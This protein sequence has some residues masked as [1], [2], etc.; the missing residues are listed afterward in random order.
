M[1]SLS[2]M[3]PHLA[4]ELDGLF[5]RDQLPQ[6]HLQRLAPAV[7]VLRLDVQHLAAVAAS[8]PEARGVGASF[9]ITPL[10]CE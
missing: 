8:P 5:P 7:V 3:L 10:Q 9:P 2:T 1:D 6:R 4:P